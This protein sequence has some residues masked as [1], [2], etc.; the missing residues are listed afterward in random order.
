MTP[1][2]ISDGQT[3]VD[4]G[5]LDGAIELRLLHGGWHSQKSQFRGIQA[6]AKQCLFVFSALPN[7]KSRS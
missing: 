5:A 2:I 3:A 1:R 7:Q 6:L 4:R